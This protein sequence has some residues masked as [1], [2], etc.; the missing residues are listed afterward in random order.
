MTALTCLDLRNNQIGDI[1]AL[2]GMTG[3]QYLY[4]SNMS[5][6]Q[7]LLLSQNQVTDVSALQNLQSLEYLSVWGNGLSDEQ[8]RNLQGSLP[9]CEVF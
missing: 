4:L 8:V 7:F 2:Q 1:S 9:G 3:M 5:S 6:A